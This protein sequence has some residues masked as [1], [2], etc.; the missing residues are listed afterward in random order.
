MKQ[1]VITPLL[2]G[3]LDIEVKNISDIKKLI[4]LDNL[5]SNED[6]L[7]NREN[8]LSNQDKDVINLIENDANVW[9]MLTNKLRNGDNDG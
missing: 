9:E 4:E 5:L 6:K 8:E 1:Q 3:T 2:N 7:D